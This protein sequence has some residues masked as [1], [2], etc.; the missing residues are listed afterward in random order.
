M[1]FRWFERRGKKTNATGHNSSQGAIKEAGITPSEARTMIAVANIPKPLFE[2]MVERDRPATVKQLVAAGRLSSHMAQRI[3]GR[4]IERARGA[5]QSAAAREGRTKRAREAT[6]ITSSQNGKS[7]LK[8]AL[9][10]VGTTKAGART[11]IAVAGSP[12]LNLR[13]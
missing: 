8:K 12:S 5:A 3:R 2:E 10:E 4:A 11:M 9:D 1:I 6:S 7:A 13:R